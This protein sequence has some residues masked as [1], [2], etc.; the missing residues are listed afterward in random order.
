MLMTFFF[1]LHSHM[2]LCLPT[3]PKME[4]TASVRASKRQRQQLQQELAAAAQEKAQAESQIPLAKSLASSEKRERDRALGALE[5]FLSSG[6]HI[7]EPDMLRLW[8]GLF[9]SMW[10]PKIFSGRLKLTQL[11]GFYHSDKPLVQQVLADELSELVLLIGGV[12]QESRGKHGPE[13]KEMTGKKRKASPSPAPEPTTEQA[14]AALA[15][16]DGFWSTMGRDWQGLDRHRVSKFFLLMR[17]FWCAGLRLL[18]AHAWNA[19]LVEKWATLLTKENSNIKRPGGPLNPTDLRVPGSIA[20]HI[21]DLAMDELD[22]LVSMLGPEDQKI[23]LL[24]SLTPFITMLRL[25]PSDALF[26]RLTERIILPLLKGSEELAQAA[27][28]AM[29]AQKARTESSDEAAV[30]DAAAA[31]AEAQLAAA[32]S[33]VPLLL[34]GTNDKYLAERGEAV[35]SGDSASAEHLAAAER[36]A[37]FLARKGTAEGLQAFHDMLHRTLFE[38]AAK[39]D[40]RGSNRNRLYRMLRFDPKAAAKDDDE[41]DW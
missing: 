1:V 31:Q 2:P 28:A 25:S 16:F 3:Q 29:A 10:R 13:S 38:A 19:D 23:D 32:A 8:K 7:P 9:Q 40:S 5:V 37:K 41:N 26:K 36:D 17:R 14:L 22:R 34:A 6:N 4:H 33:H 30:A 12:Q 15:F 20:L 27:T 11:A 39:P 18:Q 24:A 21:A 35:P